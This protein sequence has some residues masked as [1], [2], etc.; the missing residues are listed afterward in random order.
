MIMSNHFDNLLSQLKNCPRQQW[1]ETLINGITQQMK[2][3]NNPATQE[4]AQELQSVRTQIV[5]SYQQQQA[6]AASV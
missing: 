4:L 2:D 6:S 5:Q 3:S 1:T